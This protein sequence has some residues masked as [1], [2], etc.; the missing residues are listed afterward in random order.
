VEVAGAGMCHTDA[1]GRSSPIPL[2]QYPAVLGHECAG[3]VQEV[4]P[5]I[6]TLKVGDHVV[7]SLDSCGECSACVRAQ[8]AYCS[9]FFPLNFSGYRLDGSTPLTREDGTPVGGRWFGQ[10]S[11]ASHAVA[12]VRGIVRVDPSLHLD[13]L[14]PWVARCRLERGR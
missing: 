4:G 10:S 14:G 12:S 13:V 2:V 5:D 7:I 1:L 6:A 8:P 11:F 3:I 9:L